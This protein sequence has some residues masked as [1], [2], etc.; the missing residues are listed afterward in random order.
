MGPWTES[1]S[2]ACTDPS[3]RWSCGSNASLVG[4][5]RLPIRSWSILQCLKI[6]TCGTMLNEIDR[7]SVV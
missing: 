7:K 4:E 5:L 2:V 1:A 6:G 3:Q